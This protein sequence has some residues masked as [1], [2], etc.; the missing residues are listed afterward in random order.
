VV[1][2]LLRLKLLLLRNL[3]R[4]SRAQTIGIIAGIVYFSFA[5]VGVAVLLG[6]LRTSL[7]DAQVVIP[8]VGAG[9]IVLWTIV[10][11]FTF[12]SDPTLDP[13][14]FATFAVPTRDLA[15][16]LAL[17]ALIGLPAIA[18]CV[19]M[20][21]VFVAWTVTPGSAVAGLV[22]VVVGVLTAVTTS[23]WVSARATGALQS[24]R[25]R[26]ALAIAGLV[27]LLV[28]GPLV[29]FV[30]S[31]G[32][33]AKEAAGMLSDVIG[34]T[35]LGWVWAAPTDI[36]A[37]DTVT[38]LL[39]LLLGVLTLVVVGRLWAGAVS[40]Q[41]ENP[42]A[43]ARSDA[44]VAADGDLGLFAR[45]ADTPCGAVAGR[46]LTSYRRDPRFQIA[47]ITTPLVPLLLLVP[48]I[49]ADV[50][51]APLLMGPLVAFLLGF[52]E[53]NAVAYDSDAVWLH[54]VTATPG[55]ADRR[56]RLVASALLALLLVPAYALVG[57]GLGGRL[58]LLGGLLGL[59]VA[60]LGAG[61]GLSSVMNVV[62]PYPVPES[63]ES[64]FA[65]PPGAAGATLLAQTVASIGTTVIAAPVLLLA[66]LGW[67]GQAWAVWATAVLGLAL[68]VGAALVGIRIGGRLFES[69]GPELL[70]AL[71][72][73]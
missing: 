28:A 34:W 33:D 9:T 23:R 58:D 41:V 42:R 65:S 54:L 43:V 22:S 16:G 62:L 1:A 60:L 45:T 30:A 6:S 20:A 47:L 52:G 25:G 40:D 70:A 46:V 31:S 51:W 67:Q 44:G 38:G 55:V 12:G 48:F 5:V 3:F 14:R 19:I 66:W 71:R 27:L 13:A 26:D 8:L 17:S 50:L 10:P 69:R 15:I 4:R 49:A 18:T 56:G 63:G 7:D 2:H 59:S 24:R 72:R 61:Y 68:G 53:H 64:P 37:G 73:T 11:L 57:A 36:A 32:A 21:G 39:R 35:P 29:A